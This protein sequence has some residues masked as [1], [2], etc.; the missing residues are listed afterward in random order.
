MDAPAS[1]PAAAAP[2]SPSS[3]PSPA[4]SSPSPSPSSPAAPAA[5][6]AAGKDPAV[7]P[8][9]GET[10]AATAERKARKL[11]LKVDG[12]LSEVDLDSLSDEDLSLKLQMAEAARKRMQ[13]AAELKKKF[14][15]AVKLIKENPFEALKDPVFGLDLEQ[16]A[17]QHLAEKYRMEIMPEPERKQAEL[18]RRLAE[19]EKREATR[20]AELEAEQERELTERIYKETEQT[21]HQ[22]LEAAELPKNRE[23]LQA[24]AQIAQLN[25]EHGIEMTPQQIAHAAGEQLKGRSQHFLRSLK[26]Q[27]LL[28]HLGPDVVKEVMRME[29]ARVRGQ[30]VTPQEPAQAAPAEETPEDRKRD[31]SPEPRRRD[32]ITQLKKLVRGY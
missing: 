22:A 27:A 8:A 28:S 9:S 32:S 15:N 14:E 1:A 10:P 18:E 30:P 16:L 17:E 21:F 26:G 12:Q 20:L 29:V 3:S 7:T 31:R 13:E 5:P 11:Q 25:L 23:T 2:S 4:A 6:V 24:M 19:F